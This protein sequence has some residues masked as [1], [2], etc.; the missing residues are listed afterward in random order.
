[1]TLKIHSKDNGTIYTDKG[2][3]YIESLYFVEDIIIRDTDGEIFFIEDIRRD[4][5]GNIARITAE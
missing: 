3:F 5:A 2:I 4:T 1:M